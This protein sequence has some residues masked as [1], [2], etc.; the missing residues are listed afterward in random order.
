MLTLSAGGAASKSPKSLSS[1]NAKELL[2][3]TTD[4]FWT[5]DWGW[6]WGWDEGW[7]D[8]K[9]SKEGE[10]VGEEAAAKDAGVLVVGAAAAKSTKSSK[11]SSTFGAESCC[12]VGRAEDAEEEGGC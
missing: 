7:P 3:S 12:G 1:S 11:S 5:L 10:G 8:E 4:P 9:I 2:A 6:G